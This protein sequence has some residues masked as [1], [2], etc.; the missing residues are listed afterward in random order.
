ME[1][2]PSQPY[3]AYINSLGHSRLFEGDFTAKHQY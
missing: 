3:T 2:W 1:I